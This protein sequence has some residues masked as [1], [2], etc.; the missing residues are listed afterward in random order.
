MKIQC[1]LCKE[2]AELR[3]FRIV[4][5]AVE[6]TCAACRGRFTM[7]PPGAER[8]AGQRDG[9]PDT[10]PN[11]RPRDGRSIVMRCPKCRRLQELR[12]ACRECGLRT[13]LF[14]DFARDQPD[15]DGALGPLFAAC[16]AAWH[17]EAN[18]ERLLEAAS[19][20]FSFKQAARFY[21]ENLGRQAG[22]AIARRQLDRLGRMA[23]AAFM[24]QVVARAAAPEGEHPY[25]SV[26]L[27]LLVLLVLG[28]AGVGLDAILEL[29][30][31]DDLA[32]EPTRATSSVIRSTKPAR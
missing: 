9:P 2:I 15:H 6:V 19:E 1:E 17:D 10:P 16:R 4:D 23:E 24:S 13:A 7:R 18:H 21:R 30:R 11:N 25:R 32:Y 14:A 29:P 28:A 5:E 20:T 12:D 22:D 3:W 26:L 31:D 27:M 8:D